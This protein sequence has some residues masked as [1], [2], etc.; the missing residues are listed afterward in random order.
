MGSCAAGAARSVFSTRRV[1]EAVAAPLDGKCKT[2][3]PMRL[4]TLLIVACLSLAL[5]PAW[6]HAQPLA[7]NPPKAVA[8]DD[9][10]EYCIFNDRLYSVGAFIC[11]ARRLSL[12][13][14][15]PDKGGRASWKSV[16]SPDCELNQSLTPQ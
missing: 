15:R 16:A 13:C 8:D 5:V 1:S 7:I 10:K 2:K 11:V 4:L 12:Q 9:L 14:E 3:A 6:A